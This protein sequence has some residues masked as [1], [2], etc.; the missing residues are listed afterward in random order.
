MSFGFDYDFS[1]NALNPAPEL[2]RFLEPVRA[3]A[4]RWLG[5]SPTDIRHALVA[6]YQPG[7]ALGWHRDAPQF[8]QVCG[9][10][11]ASS[12]RM[13]F[14]RFPPRKERKSALSLELAPRSA[15][16]LRDDARWR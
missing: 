12:C 11:L 16:V 5:V 15:Y 14:R 4:A 10:S 8:G 13:R 6:E 1:T 2:P 9:V 3:Q 7:T